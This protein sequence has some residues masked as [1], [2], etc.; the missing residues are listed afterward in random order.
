MN[1]R[2]A[3]LVMAGAGAALLLPALLGGCARIS[4]ESDPSEVG[5]GII[6]ARLEVMVEPPP[7][8][9]CFN[10]ILRNQ[11]NVETST[12]TPL[13]PSM[14][15]DIPVGAYQVT[16]QAYQASTCTAPP[17]SPTWGTAQPANLV[18]QAG[19]M[20][21]LPLLLFRVGRVDVTPVFV[22]TPEV[23]VAGQGQLGPITAAGDRL[24]WVAG[25]R[26]VRFADDDTVGLPQ[27]IATNQPRSVEISLEPGSGDIYW[28][29]GISGERDAMGQFIPDGSIWRYNAATGVSAAI[30]QNEAAPLEIDASS[31]SVYWAASGSNEIKVFS[32]VTSTVSQLI[33]NQAGANSVRVI[34]A[35]MSFQV[36]WTTLA[37]A[38]RLVD[39]PGATPVDVFVE[40]AGDPRLPASVTGDGTDVFWTDFDSTANQSRILR[41]PA[42]G[43][44]AQVLYPPPGQHLG[45]SFGIVTAGD[46]V[47]VMGFDGLKRLRK[48]GS[49]LLEM[50]QPGQTRGRA[51]TSRDGAT[52]LYW[53]D[54]AG[55]GLVWRLRVQ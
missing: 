45:P 32:P 3:T 34:P 48:D 52:Y 51:V 17:Q 14:S 28:I 30:A 7:D 19:R 18:V 10:L 25:Q 1:K 13:L 11:E 39:L 26:V 9:N 36:L 47:Y 54:N 16:A 33:G 53:T 42:T 20:V 6:Q 2:T 44:T 29:S 23:V 31:G 4:A 24:A 21:S 5:V 49:G 50:I 41:A 55:G 8:V 15:F 43:G 22:A 35:N 27:V 40:P 12:Q 46:F 37:G 38:V